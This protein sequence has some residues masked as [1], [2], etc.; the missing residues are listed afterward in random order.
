MRTT[1]EP[2]S[3]PSRRS[4]SSGTC[5]SRGTVAKRAGQASGTVAPPPSPNRFSCAVQAA[6]GRHVFHD[7][8]YALAG[9]ARDRTG[10]LCNFSSR[11]LRCGH[12]SGISALGMSCGIEIATSPVPGGRSSRRTSRSPQNTSAKNCWIARCSIGPRQTTACPSGT[13]MPFDMTF[14][15][16]ATWRNN[17]SVNNC[18]FVL[19]T[20]HA[21]DGETVNISVNEADLQSFA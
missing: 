4:T 18:R 20:H 9:L 14:T 11:D 1:G 10:T 8:D 21:R 7:A 13:N 5:A 3:P 6:V 17:H 16:W 15:S 2:W 19:N 12:N